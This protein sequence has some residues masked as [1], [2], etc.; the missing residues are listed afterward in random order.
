[1]QLDQRQTDW[2]LTRDWTPSPQDAAGL[3]ARVGAKN[4]VKAKIAKL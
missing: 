4:P 2:K 1:L 3:K